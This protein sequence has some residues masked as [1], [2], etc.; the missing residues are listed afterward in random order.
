MKMTDEEFEQEIDKINR[1]FRVRLQR[2]PV[3][4]HLAYMYNGLRLSIARLGR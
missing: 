2:T 3:L 4:R 1:S